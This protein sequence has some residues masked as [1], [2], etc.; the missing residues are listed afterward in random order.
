MLLA[1]GLT[2]HTRKVIV[3]GPEGLC[4]KGNIEIVCE[5]FGVR[6]F[7]NFEDLS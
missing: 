6:L 3:G 2:T 7:T 1:L 4:R 5:R